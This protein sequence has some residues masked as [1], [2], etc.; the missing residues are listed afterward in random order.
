MEWYKDNVSMLDYLPQC[1]SSADLFVAMAEGVDYG[2]SQLKAYAE[3][4]LKN[5]YIGTV[6]L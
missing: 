1:L 6:F 2:V 4:V 3:K 5:C